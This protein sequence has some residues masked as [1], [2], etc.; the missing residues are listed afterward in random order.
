MTADSYH[1][2]S[3]GTGSLKNLL[4]TKSTNVFKALSIGTCTLT[5]AQKP[6]RSNG[7]TLQRGSLAWPVCFTERQRSPTLGE[8]IFAYMDLAYG[9][10][11]QF[12]LNDEQLSS[13]FV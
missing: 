8:V 4:I 1:P 2:Q 5:C 3:K 9:E 11:P 7:L 13:F 6:K 12:L 10:Q